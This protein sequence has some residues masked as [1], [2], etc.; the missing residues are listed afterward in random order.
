[1]VGLHNR[2]KQSDTALDF[3]SATSDPIAIIGSMRPRELLATLRNFSP[4]EN[5]EVPKVNVNGKLNP[6]KDPPSHI[7]ATTRGKS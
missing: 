7:K 3:T 6:I 5:E 2:K 1:M 4:I